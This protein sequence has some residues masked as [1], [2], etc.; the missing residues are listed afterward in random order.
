MC[1]L[2]CNRFLLITALGFLLSCH[3]S[4]AQHGGEYNIIAWGSAGLYRLNIDNSVVTTFNGTGVAAGLGY[5]M[6][7]KKFIFQVGG[8]FQLGNSSMEMRDFSFDIELFDTEGERYTGHYLFTSNTDHY[9]TGMVNVPFM[10]GLHLG[11]RMYFLAGGKIGVHIFTKSTTVSQ[12]ESSGT[13]HNLIDDF[14]NMP[15]HYFGI[16]DEITTFDVLFKSNFSFSA[17][18][19]IYLS[20]P[21]PKTL[22]STLK[23]AYRVSVFAD[24]GLANLYDNAIAGPSYINKMGDSGYQP[25][26]N[27]FVMTRKFDIQEVKNFYVGLKLTLLMGRDGGYEC[28]CLWY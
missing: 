6:H 16:K 20:K 28:N 15:N 8:E 22:Q 2:T 5:E 19:G 1:K 14:G 3:H 11:S 4:N 13:Y 23:T 17:E 7:R 9:R 10:L 24:Y 27:S 21:T 12:V 25:A 18:V 26:K